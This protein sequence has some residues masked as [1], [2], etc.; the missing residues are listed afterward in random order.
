MKE[1]VSKLILG[2]YVSLLVI[3]YTYLY[4]HPLTKSYDMNLNL[5]VMITLITL[6]DIKTKC[7]SWAL[8]L[9][10]IGILSAEKERHLIRT[11]PYILSG[12]KT[13]NFI[14]TSLTEFVFVSSNYAQVIL[15]RC[16]PYFCVSTALRNREYNFCLY[17]LENKKHV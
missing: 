3:R 1:S 6:Y 17:F 10:Y 13:S 12:D 2:S 15:S 16:F 5:K 14:S 7:C 4:S 11:L 8:F 9:I